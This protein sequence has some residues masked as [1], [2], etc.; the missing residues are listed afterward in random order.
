M[1]SSTYVQLK[2]SQFAHRCDGGV[3]QNQ[4]KDECQDAFVAV[5]DGIYPDRCEDFQSASGDTAAH[6]G[7]EM[8]TCNR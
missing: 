2:C 3:D 8:R 1:P 5:A 7:E 4:D 6:K